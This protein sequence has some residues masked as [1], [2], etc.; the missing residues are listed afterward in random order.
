MNKLTIE[1]TRDQLSV[2]IEA[3]NNF[4]ERWLAGWELDGIMAGKDKADYMIELTE[5]LE[6]V[7]K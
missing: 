1:L 3:L 6:Q 5:Q 7:A 2:V 4:D